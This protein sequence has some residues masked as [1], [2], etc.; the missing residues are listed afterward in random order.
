M[1]DCTLQAVRKFFGK[2]FEQ[3]CIKHNIILRKQESDIFMVQNLKELKTCVN[4]IDTYKANLDSAL[5]RIQYEQRKRTRKQTKR[6]KQIYHT[7]SKNFIFTGFSLR[8]RL[9][10]TS[11]IIPSCSVNAVS[12]IC[13][14]NNIKRGDEI[15]DHIIKNTAKDVV[16]TNY[17][18][19]IPLISDLLSQFQRRHRKFDYNSVLMSLIDKNPVSQNLK[20]E[21]EVPVKQLMSFYEIIF[22]KV[23]PLAIFGKLKNLKKAKKALKYLLTTPR[24]RSYDLWFLLEKLDISSIT[25]LRNI[26]YPETQWLILAKF[27]KWFFKGYLIKILFKHFH[28]TSLSSGNNE[29]LY[30]AR[31]TW[32]SIQKKFVTKKIRSNALHPDVEYDEWSPPI[33]IYKLYPKYSGV[34]PILV[35]KHEKN[36]EHNLY[37]IHTFLKQLKITAYGFSNFQEDW[38][39][40]VHY[41]HNS[42]IQKPYL[43]SCDVMDAFGSIIQ[44]DLH[45]IIISL[46]EQLPEVLLLHLYIIK[47]KRRVKDDPLCYKEFFSNEN[48]QLPLSPGT[49]Y[50]CTKS[51]T[52][53]IQKSW[54]LDKIWDYI[55]YQRVKI[56]NKTRII[57]KGVVQ[58]TK[59]SPILSDIYYNYILQKEM[60]S[61]LKYG[62][63]IKY[64]DDIL[65]ITHDEMQAKQFLQVIKKGFPK[66]N[67]YF[68]DSKIQTNITSTSITVTNNINYIGYKINCNNLEI[69]PK[70][71]NTHVRYLLSFKSKDDI[72]PLKLFQNQVCNVNSLKL[73]KIVFDTSINSKL[74][75]IKILE[76]VSL[77]QAKRAQ[78]LINELLDNIKYI[79]EDII[80]IIEFSNRRV[81]RYIIKLLMK[82]NENMSYTKAC[83][84]DRKIS[85][86]I[87]MSYK[88]IFKRD[89]IL[90]KYFMKVPFKQARHKHER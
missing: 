12:T 54:L 9:L 14:L 31:S 79:V 67:C 37:I 15:F 34:R 51:A 63:I 66:Y 53:P 76:E 24:Y 86:I 77:M 8:V 42:K 81:T 75:I 36:D 52:S 22:T 47:S 64:V 3:Y 44:G 5:K 2:W 85:N 32:F 6:T 59:L 40:I 72:T 70:F 46:C 48:L 56:G 38:K 41:T 27:I 45:D 84:W 35:S 69:M 78:V 89:R 28:I 1:D 21:Y 13:I 62:K 71:S 68:K 57:S 74:T 60:S 16:V 26:P 29:R 55:S 80:R 65:Y 50:V 90:R 83:A 11:A 58:G 18:L 17:E 87:W 49:L 43:V 25:W 10:N 61:F 30:I 19:S 7:G 23:V 20:C 4:Q 33:G 73:S 88:R 82:C 39:S